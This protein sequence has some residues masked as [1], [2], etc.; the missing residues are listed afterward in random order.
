MREGRPWRAEGKAFVGDVYMLDFWGPRLR[1]RSR[2]NAFFREGT[3]DDCC[4]YFSCQA[5]VF[6]CVRGVIRI[7]VT[8]YRVVLY[9]RDLYYAA[10]FFDGLWV[11]A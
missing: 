6:Y 8:F 7:D 2:K 4:K 11:M 3:V 9:L 5:K 1:F 10:L